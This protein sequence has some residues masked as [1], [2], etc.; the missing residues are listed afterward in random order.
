MFRAARE[1]SV[2][3]QVA[4]TAGQTAVFWCVFLAAIPLSIVWL[5]RP[6]NVPEFQ[7]AIAP[8]VGWVIFGLAGGLGLWS[9]YTMSVAGRGTPLPM[10]CPRS[11]VITGP[12]AHVRNPMA[13]A[14]LTQGAAVA[15][16]LGSYIVLAYVAVGVLVWNYLVRPLEEENLRERFGL[17]YEVYCRNVACWRWNCRAYRCKRE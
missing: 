16:T 6:L 9:G 1:G 10:D 12:Y 3:W 11:L 15:V 4:K 8:W 17:P 13:M 14:G 7:G 2:S 5:E